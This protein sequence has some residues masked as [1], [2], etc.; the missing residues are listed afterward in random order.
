MS[1]YKPVRALERGLS[2][3]RAINERDG[4]RTQEVAAACGLSRP[5]AFRLLETLEG[6][7]FAQ[8]SPSDGVW[9]PTVFC[10]TLS[11]G[12]LDKAWIGQIAMPEMMRLGERILWP[13]DLVTLSG[14]AML[15]R[16]T[17]HKIS[18]FSFDVGMVGQTVPLLLTAGGRAYLAA[19]PEEEV[20]Q[21]LEIMRASDLPEHQL[22]HDP[23]WIANLIKVTREKGF[24]FRSVEFKAHTVSISVPVKKDGRPIAALT[25]VCLK[26]AVTIEEAA[27]KFAAPLRETVARIEAQIA[28]RPAEAEPPRFRSSGGAG[29]AAAAG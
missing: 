18:P 2:I 19:A 3:L 24:G 9:R 6:M 23:R 14:A 5:T 22:A 8:Q 10:N 26:S 21:I 29:T 4:M 7:G 27:R 17:T 12:Y 25:V 28:A 20:Q 13:V 1:V 15:V 16:E 11:A